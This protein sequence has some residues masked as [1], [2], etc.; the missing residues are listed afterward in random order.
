MLLAGPTKRK[1]SFV[2]WVSTTMSWPIPILPT[3]SRVRPTNEDII[4]E[5]IRLPDGQQYAVADLVN[6]MTGFHNI[7]IRTGLPTR[8]TVARPTGRPPGTTK[9][10]TAERE[11]IA[12]ASL[13]EISDRYPRTQA[14][15]IRL[16]HE[17][18]RMLQL[19]VKSIY[20]MRKENGKR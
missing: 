6:R 17:S 13:A 16:L 2:L 15:A 19:P 8:Y 1:S 3:I 9:Y 4:P 12:Q 10:S 20:L 7:N 18:R 11:W 5:F 14:Q